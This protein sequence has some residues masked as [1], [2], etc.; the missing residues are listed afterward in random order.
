MKIGEIIL[1]KQGK[2]IPLDGIVIEGTSSINALALTGEAIPQQA[3]IGDAVL[4]GTIAID[5]ILKNRSK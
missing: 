1:V 3:N 2:K 5:G 4:S